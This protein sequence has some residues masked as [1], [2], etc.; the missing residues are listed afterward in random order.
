MAECN[1]HKIHSDAMGKIQSISHN[2]IKYFNSNKVDILRN[3]MKNGRDTVD[4]NYPPPYENA[5]IFNITNYFSDHVPILKELD[6]MIIISWNIGIGDNNSPYP[7]QII[8]EGIKY[9][10][11]EQFKNNDYFKNETINCLVQIINCY[12]RE[13]SKCGKNIVLHLQECSF[14]AYNK[15]KIIFAGIKYSSGFM[16]QE[17]AKVKVDEDKLVT[18]LFYIEECLTTYNSNKLKLG[19]SSFIFGN[20]P[21][22]DLD[23]KIYPTSATL[24]ESITK[25]YNKYKVHIKNEEELIL[26]S[27][28]NLVLI[29]INDKKYIHYNLH[30]KKLTCI[31]DESTRECD[32]RA[33]EKSEKILNTYCN[34]NFINILDDRIGRLDIKFTQ[35][36]FSSI[37]SN[38]LPNNIYEIDGGE[39][40]FKHEEQFNIPGDRYIC[41]DYNALL[42]NY[43]GLLDDIRNKIVIESKSSG[44]DYIIKIKEEE[45]AAASSTVEDVAMGGGWEQK[46]LKYKQKYLK[47]KNKLELY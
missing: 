31:K 47:L 30:I 6:D 20:R 7:Y 32:I 12:I 34:N 19:L 29:K 39:I 22:D 26:D 43:I 27:R 11:R 21:V 15:I 42:H 16:P 1:I 37:D 25:I 41:G 8:E 35:V 9:K 4:I 17:I 45:A 18:K 44:V 40:L 5:K 24:Y 23:I 36:L 33:V 46:Y 28:I 13:I 14:D 2:F 38:K 3:F 10:K